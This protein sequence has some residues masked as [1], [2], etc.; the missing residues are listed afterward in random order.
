[1]ALKKIVLDGKKD[2]PLSFKVTPE[3]LESC[4]VKMEDNLIKHGWK[5]RAGVSSNK[6][7]SQNKSSKASKKT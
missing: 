6:N 4:M 7:F 3:L 1:M 2:Y 5:G